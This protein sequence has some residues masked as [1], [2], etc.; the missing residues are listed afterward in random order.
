MDTESKQLLREL[1]ASL[2]GF[3]RQAGMFARVAK[4]Q[5][6]NT[7]GGT[8]GAGNGGGDGID[9]WFEGRKKDW[10]ASADSMAR[11][12]SAFNRTSES[13]VGGFKALTK[14]SESVTQSFLNLSKGLLGG[15]LI[16]GMVEVSSSLTRSYQDLSEA[17]A[18]FSDSIMGLAKTALESG[19]SMEEAVR[20]SKRNATVAA[21]LANNRQ[22]GLLALSAAVR[23]NAEEFGSFG[24]TVAGLDDLVGDYA[25]TMRLQGRLEKMDRA[26]TADSMLKVAAGADVLANQ[27]GKS[28]K[29]LMDTANAAMRDEVYRSRMSQMSEGERKKYGDAFSTAILGFSA[30]AGEAGKTLSKML[31][32]T[33]AYDGRAENSDAARE[34]FNKVLPQGTM[35][36]RKLY[37][38]IKSDPA[39]A[40]KYQ[41]EYTNSMKDL[42]DQNRTSLNAQVEGG[43]EY[44][45]QARKIL[46]IGDNLQKADAETLRKQLEINNLQEKN[47]DALSKLALNFENIWMR[48]SSNVLMKFLPLIVKPME[49]IGRGIDRFANSNAWKKA[50]TQFGTL[51]EAITKFL[52]GFLTDTRM[53]SLAQWVG[54]TIGKWS[55][56]VTNIKPEV[57]QGFFTGLAGF[58]D[59][60]MKTM[61]LFGEAIKGVGTIAGFAARNLDVLAGIA[62]A[63]GTAFAAMKVVNFAN[64]IKE[65]FTGRNMTIAARNV[66]VNGSA[67]GGGGSHGGGHGGR[68]GRA[69]GG[70]RGRLAGAAILA[71]GM[72]ALGQRMGV[73]D[74]LFRRDQ[75][76]REEGQ[77]T[78]AE[79]NQAQAPLPE[80]LDQFTRNVLEMKKE[81]NTASAE[82]LAR[83]KADDDA[84]AAR[85]ARAA[86]Q[87]NTDQPRQPDAP[88][89]ND[90]TTPSAGVVEQAANIAA[91]IAPAVASTAG[92]A[93]SRLGR[94]GA[95]AAAPVA[96]AAI[97]GG[98][99]AATTAAT[100]ARSAGLLGRAASGLA[101]F[102]KKLPVVGAAVSA[103]MTAVDMYKLKQ[104]HD[105]GDITDAEYQ[106]GMAKAVANGLIDAV[107]GLGLVNAG[108]DMVTGRSLGDRAVDA[109]TPASPRDQRNPANDRSPGAQAAAA[110][111][112]RSPTITSDNLAERLA[113]LETG[114]AITSQA[115]SVQDAMLKQMEEMNN[116]LGAMLVQARDSADRLVRAQNQTITTIQNTP[117]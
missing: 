12:G 31:S 57:V 78:Q 9:D 17:G 64:S 96:G 15:A 84:R 99:T 71:T 38:Q 50:E 5:G 97:E 95:S 7:Q 94:A 83:L 58:G 100:A 11:F 2:E 56:A 23:K 55:T 115:S 104:Q 67:A 33:A 63:L 62:I 86:G 82:E 109:L 45:A 102:A 37:A 54:D 103:G 47:K 70:M 113:N 4:Q 85:T 13:M 25:E 81:R 69:G 3:N 61:G 19:T 74:G 108:L 65:M 18:R 105:K 88:P 20:L 106:D 46:D 93:V 60:F 49:A 14:G 43:G 68:E 76:I 89:A 40:I 110:A 22:G 90:T 8:A 42:I 112:P 48:F 111:T 30:Q 91:A 52:D 32:Q 87:T 73:F 107:P 29:E 36:M 75:Q 44:A 28:R 16:G 27:F 101:S 59:L 34:L 79:Q 117:N 51:G 21:A 39:N 92:L 10:D 77:R 26:S 24:Y 116:R 35:M 6:S 114:R 80:V 53:N 98:A 41:T 66:Y 1:R 72:L